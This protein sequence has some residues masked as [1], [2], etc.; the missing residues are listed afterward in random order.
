MVNLSKYSQEKFVNREQALALIQE[1]LNTLY[2]D[3]PLKESELIN[4]WGMGGK[5]KSFLK[6]HIKQMYDSKNGNKKKSTLSTYIII[7]W[8]GDIS[9]NK[10]YSIPEILIGF[11]NKFIRYGF[12]MKEFTKF[13]TYYRKCTLTSLPDIIDEN[14]ESVTKSVFKGLFDLISQATLVGPLI[15]SSVDVAQTTNRKKKNKQLQ[16]EFENFSSFD[17]GTMLAILLEAF[18]E[19][20]N[21]EAKQRKI[22]F[23]IDTFEDVRSIN[24]DWIF[25]HKTGFKHIPSL[26]YAI[27]PSLWIVFGREKANLNDKQTSFQLKN[28]NNSETT[29]YMVENLPMVPEESAE[30]I[31]SYSSGYPLLLADLHSELLTTQ[32][33][34]TTG[35]LEQLLSKENKEV[36]IDRYEKYFSKNFNDLENIY[37]L[38][39]MFAFRYWTI[40]KADITDSNIYQFA[41]IY[42]TSNGNK[43]QTVDLENRLQQLLQLSFI[44]KLSSSKYETTYEINKSIYTALFEQTIDGIPVLPSKLKRDVISFLQDKLTKKT[45]D[46]HETDTYHYIESNENQAEL[47]QLIDLSLSLYKDAEPAHQ[48]E[49]VIQLLQ[50]MQADELETA[51]ILTVMLERFTKEFLATRSGQQIIKIV[52]HHFQ[53][54]EIVDYTDRF[55]HLLD[56]VHNEQALNEKLGHYFLSIGRLSYAKMY[57]EKAIPALDKFKDALVFHATNED[58]IYRHPALRSLSVMPAELTEG[59]QFDDEDSVIHDEEMYLYRKFLYN[60]RQLIRVNIELGD[61]T[62]VRNLMLHWDTAIGIDESNPDE[63]LLHSTWLQIDAIMM[64]NIVWNPNVQKELEYAFLPE[65]VRNK[66]LVIQHPAL[67][68]RILKLSNKLLELKQYQLHTRFY[69]CL[70][71][72]IL[73]A[74]DLETD[75]NKGLAPLYKVIKSARYEK[76]LVEKDMM[77]YPFFAEEAEKERIKKGILNYYEKR[78]DEDWQQP[79]NIEEIIESSMIDLKLMEF[80]NVKDHYE[81][82][83]NNVINKLE[84][85]AKDSF[86]LG[87]FYYLKG[88]D[89]LANHDLLE[90]YTYYHKERNTIY[91]HLGK[92]AD[93]SHIFIPYETQDIYMRYAL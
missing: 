36:F 52:L 44:D 47:N 93:T 8:D 73:L 14:E 42:F 30:L 31:F 59:I 3:P 88:A 69:D 65:L 68:I 17:T 60:T 58:N 23:M 35:F 26:F 46:F 66:H 77:L 56:G 32:E 72:I 28:F 51:F 22:I 85:L 24:M 11:R 27:Q 5:G 10:T 55:V 18:I 43:V 12:E 67:I 34:L 4:F 62:S 49:K 71:D 15:Q 48:Y 84:Q 87:E 13:I 50:E 61:N 63:N 37:L 70:V 64:Q 2:E 75:E 78:V 76:Y 29:K 92:F 86:H 74:T 57:L 19:D 79:L 33:N 82:V 80:V 53:T 20:I 40:N 41:K 16:K 6:K 38:K 45:D 83:L 9:L 7:D 1:K 21:R 90:S 39:I 25:A 91:Q 54:F 89:L 81:Y